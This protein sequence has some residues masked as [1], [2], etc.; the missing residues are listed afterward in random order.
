M[1]IKKKIWM[2]KCLNC[3]WNLVFYNLPE[4]A[5]ALSGYEN[6]NLA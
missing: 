2:K 6:F 4:K 3:Q 5:I 1:K